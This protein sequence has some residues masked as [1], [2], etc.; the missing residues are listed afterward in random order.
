[1]ESSDRKDKAKL[2]E[3]LPHD[4]IV[5][6]KFLEEKEIFSI[7]FDLT[8]KFHKKLLENEEYAKDAIIFISKNLN[9]LGQQIS[10]C[11]WNVIV[12][13]GSYSLT[14]I[15]ND[16]KFCQFSIK[17]SEILT[18]KYNNDKCTISTGE[19]KEKIG[20]KNSGVSTQSLPH[21]EMDL[22]A[23]HIWLEEKKWEYCIWISKIDRDHNF[24]LSGSIDPANETFKKIVKGLKLQFYT[25]S[26]AYPIKKK[27]SKDDG[28][29]FSWSINRNGKCLFYIDNQLSWEL[30]IKHLDIKLQPCGLTTMEFKEL[31]E[32]LESSKNNKKVFRL[33]TAN[34]IG[35]KELIER[36]FKRACLIYQKVYFEGLYYPIIVKIDKSKGPYEIEFIGAEGPTR[37]LQDVTIRAFETVQSLSHLEFLMDSQIQISLSNNKMVSDS[38]KVVSSQQQ[39]IEDFKTDIDVF[40]T[41]HVTSSNSLGTIQVLVEDSI[42]ETQDFKNLYLN[43]FETLN[44]D[45]D[46][47][48]TPFKDNLEKITDI[49]KIMDEND[50]KKKEILDTIKVSIEQS[51]DELKEEFNTQ[52]IGF[53]TN[54]LPD[55]IIVKD[56][57][58]IIKND[59]Q[60][61]I[62]AVGALDIQINTKL[63]DLKITISGVRSDFTN[64]LYLIIRH[65][66]KIPHQTAAEISKITKLSQKTIYKS[67][68]LLQD[69]NLID[70]IINKRKKGRPLRLFK[71]R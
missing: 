59:L 49:L 69:R 60:D 28:L 68:K 64:N 47:F 12:K 66:S 17:N 4:L 10:F 63:D 9:K 44:L 57:L 39:V 13:T 31:L 5:L 34:A 53:E 24:K 36:D 16:Y 52:F 45:L 51:H 29:Y 19:K 21:S 35:P 37:R 14:R 22:S 38:L 58:N 61:T 26:W 7:N 62:K 46:S 54:Y 32:C 30:F 25:N 33:E 27:G 56:D 40:K 50:D 67:L 6:L 70:V 65:L 23:L 41:N 42:K 71:L 43:D 18:S 20:S 15:L 3:N 55:M 2:F 1:M 48:F 8:I 11:I